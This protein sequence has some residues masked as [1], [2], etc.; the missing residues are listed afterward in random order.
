MP[1]RT[2]ELPAAI[3]ETSPGRFKTFRKQQIYFSSKEI[4]IA[5]KELLTFSGN[6]N[7]LQKLPKGRSHY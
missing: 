4:K 5:M 7:K 6:F 1:S 3:P 2:G